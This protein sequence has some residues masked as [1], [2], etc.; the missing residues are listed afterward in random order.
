MK[1]ICFLLIAIVATL[2]SNAQDVARYE[3]D[4]NDFTELKVTEGINVDYK[5]NADSVGKAVFYATPEMASA[6]MFS[7][8]KGKLHIELAQEAENAVG[9]PTV[10]VYSRFLTKAENSGDS[11]MRVLSVADCP[12]FK[13]RI[14]GNGRLSVREINATTVNASIDTGNG[15]IVING[16]C[17]YAKLS[18]K[19][20]GTIEAD[21]LVA[22]DVKC[23]LV[24]TGSIGCNVS[25]QL[26]IVGASSGHLYYRGTP[27]GIKNNSIGV[28]IVP[29][30]N[31]K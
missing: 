24:G 15:T 20:A 27:T 8:K 22:K 18:Y 4:V 26:T 10:T 11:L 30:D 21:G 14:V 9:V 1:K 25:G 19:G 31:E 23:T 28:D 17:D 13:A 3:L 5:C 6:L 16:R 12:E 7:N 2:M 29:L